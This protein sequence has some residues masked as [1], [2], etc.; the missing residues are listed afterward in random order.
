[1]L[2]WNRNSSFTSAMALLSIAA[3]TLKKFSEWVLY[4][5]PTSTTRCRSIGGG[6][7]GGGGTAAMAGRAARRRG[8]P[9]IPR[10]GGQDVFGEGPP[11]WCNCGTSDA[12]CLRHTVWIK[13][14]MG[15]V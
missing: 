15:T 12:Q 14:T 3:V 10:S 7:G 11:S 4:L 5:M 8:P 1:M 9:R 6:P 2:E 13:S